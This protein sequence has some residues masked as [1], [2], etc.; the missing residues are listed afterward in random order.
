MPSKRLNWHAL[1]QRVNAA[2]LAN[3]VQALARQV[4]AAAAAGAPKPAALPDALRER[5]EKKYETE[6]E[7]H[8]AT[9]RKLEEI[10]QHPAFNWRTIM[11]W[12]R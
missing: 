12:F 8:A 7:R 4:A 11:V 10:T 5:L 1:G 6:Q 2:K 9:K 3:G